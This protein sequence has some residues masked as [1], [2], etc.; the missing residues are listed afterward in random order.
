[1][2]PLPHHPPAAIRPGPVGPRPGLLETKRLAALAARF[3]GLHLDPEKT[4]FFGHRLNKRLMAQGLDDFRDYCDFLE[5]PAGRSELRLFIEAMTTHTTSF[6]REAKHFE[7]LETQGWAELIAGGAGLE[8]PLRIWSAAC[9]NG[10][11]LF[12]ALISLKEHEER[13]GVHLRIEGVGTDLSQAILKSAARAVYTGAEIKGLSEA[14]RRRFILRARNGADMFRIVPDLRRLTS[15]TWL[16]L[17]K[18][19]NDGPGRADLVMLR[20]VLIYFDPPTRDR[21]VAALCARLAPGGI[22]MTGHS[23]TL[24]KLPAG[25]VQAGASIYRK[26][27]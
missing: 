18:M 5:S 14:R 24:S 21:A 22:L 20:N 8:W 16:N 3:G 23:E 27:G 13:H 9:S 11:E 6:F 4:E 1:M 7:W 17:T 19:G 15:W 10:A 25:M 12:S 26:E 2:K